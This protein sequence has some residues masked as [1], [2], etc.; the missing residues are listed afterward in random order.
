MGTWYEGMTTKLSGQLCRCPSTDHLDID[1]DG[2]DV[3]RMQAA[4]SPRVG[5]LSWIS[6]NQAHW[7]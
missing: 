1:G 7:E 4:R 6:R 2:F 3:A 5:E